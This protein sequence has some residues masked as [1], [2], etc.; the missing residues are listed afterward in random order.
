MLVLDRRVMDRW[1]G[2]VFLA[3]LPP[4][5]RATGPA[6]SVLDQVAERTAPR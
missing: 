4:M 1:Y 6:R 3:S 2:R 5:R